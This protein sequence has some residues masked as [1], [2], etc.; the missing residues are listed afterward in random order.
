MTKCLALILAGGRGEGLG[1]LT[2]YN[3]KP[4]VNFG[5]NHRIIDFALGNCK[6]S[7]ISEIGVLSQYFSD[8]LHKYIDS[9]YGHSGLYMLPAYLTGS[10]YAGS[11][12]A[13]YKNMR[14]IDR[15]NPDFL[16]IIRGDQVYDM[17]YRKFINYHDSTRA[18]VTEA[19][20]R[21]GSASRGERT[22]LGV[23]VF[24]WDAL[25]SYLIRDAEDVGSGHDLAG[26]ILP[27]MRQAHEPV[28]AYP[29]K[30]YWRPIDTLENLWEAN[31]ELLDE[32]TASVH[33]DESNFYI[34]G[35]KRRYLTKPFV[36]HSA[37]RTK[38]LVSGIVEHSVLGDS[39]QVMPGAEVVNSIIMPNAYIGK[40]VRIFN[41]IIGAGAAI[42]DNTIIGD[43]Y[44][45]DF[46]VEP[47]L[48][49]GGISL[50]EPG[51]YIP[52]G[53]TIA[54]GSHID[55]AMMLEWTEQNLVIA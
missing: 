1:S 15:F 6:A 20:R 24:N 46:F 45:T 41:A 34:N 28:N 35:G 49:T 13:I 50:V 23:Y 42:M 17:D 51:L 9:A 36:G 31:M 52:K 29:F 22:P 18:A 32:K 2:M 40:N 43:D 47:E 55:N 27:A 39:V 37:V 21:K 48:C 16:L 53:L 30:G 14:F 12:D 5:V 11:A 7:G 44:G 8:D 38:N 19:F 3:A 54:S 26:D 25:K 10:L 33:N 4:A